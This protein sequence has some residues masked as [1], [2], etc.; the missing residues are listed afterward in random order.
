MWFLLI[1]I[2]CVMTIHAEENVTRATQSLQMNM[3]EWMQGVEQLAATISLPVPLKTEFTPD[4]LAQRTLKDVV[5]GQLAT[6]RS[7]VATAMINALE[8]EVTVCPA[9]HINDRIIRAMKEELEERGFSVHTV[10]DSCYKKNGLL[11]RVPKPVIESD[12]IKP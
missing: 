6:F 9:M 8:D 11:V 12:D 5:R 10:T 4:Y 3:T 1:A 7:Q 2:F